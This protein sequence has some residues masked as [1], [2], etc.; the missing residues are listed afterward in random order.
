L[1]HNCDG[2]AGDSN[3][4]VPK[5]AASSDFVVTK[6]GTAV[7]ISQSQMKKGFDEAG[8]HS[9]KSKITDETAVIYTVPTSRG[10]IDVRTME[11]G[12]N[13]PRRAVFSTPGQPR[14]PRTP[15]GR[16]PRGTKQ[17]QRAASH[18]EQSQ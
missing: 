3:A 1:V 16:T 4:L 15:D 9:S 13:H 14:S 8:F 12:A 17:Q 6:D 11:G 18:L 7:P 2:K 5:K 10:P